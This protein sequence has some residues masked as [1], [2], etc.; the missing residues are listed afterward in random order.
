MKH[1]KNL[2]ETK[3]NTKQRNGRQGGITL[4]A[5]IITI[6]ILVILAAVTINVVTN[7]DLIGQAT[8]GA[9]RYKDSAN[10]EQEIL[11]SLG[12]YGGTNTDKAVPEETLPDNTVDTKAGTKVKIPNEWL[13]ETVG[14][15]VNQNGVKVAS[16]TKVATVY[17]VS[18]G[19]GNT[20]PIPEKF[21]YVGGDI[22]TGI[23]ISD[24]END[25]D[26]YANDTN[27]DVGID[28]VGNQFVWIPCTYENYKK[29][30]WSSDGKT[31][32][33]VTNRSNCYWDT[34]TPSSEKA[35]I[36]KYGGFYVGRYEA[37]SGTVTGIDFSSA[38]T[39]TT[40]WVNP[41]YNYLN[42]TGGNVES[43][44]NEIPFYHAD[45]Y[46]AVYMSEK[47]YKDDTA[48]KNYVDSGLITGTM[49]DAMINK[50]NEKSS[51]SLTSS[52]WGNYY[53]N[54]VTGCRGK[55]TRIT[56]SNGS[57]T[58]WADNNAGTNEYVANDH[59]TL[60]ST[61][62]NDSFQKYH[63]YDVAG[64][65]WE[66][67]TENARISGNDTA[68]ESRSVFRS[69]SFGHAFASYPACF[70][71]RNVASSTSTTYGFRV[72]LFIK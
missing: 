46:T 2:A 31:Q 23:V 51:A 16:T 14:C 10:K 39:C 18:D 56:T 20:I 70:R 55:Y 66:W 36:E 30:N 61:G 7:A 63:I 4:I 37:G 11:N 43:K 41:A 48:R 8:N 58:A 64:N 33:N 22:N 24:N 44:A 34:T 57:N 52:D 65:L 9:E 5:L 42:V 29:S 27:K 3:T 21:W 47:M 68:T 72:A 50:I 13:T 28:L 62:S 25:K 1:L 71:G 53:D 32:G 69:G 49:W 35:Q 12:L 6:I 67:T 45:Y 17:A 38:Y 59:Y 40:A 26:K 15:Y 54:Q 19:L 60:L